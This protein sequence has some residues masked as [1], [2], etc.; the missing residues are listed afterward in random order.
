MGVSIWLGINAMKVL[1]ILADAGG[2]SVRM[3]IRGRGK[4][5]VVFEQFGPG[6]L[7]PWAK[8]QNG[9]AEFA[10]AVIYEHAGGMA[11]G[12]GLPPRDGKRISRELRD[13]LRSADLEPPFVMVGY[14]MAG[15]YVR[16]F[17]GEYPD[18]VAGLVLIDPSKEKFFEWLWENDPESH[19]IANWHLQ[20]KT[21]LGMT[22]ETFKQAA[23][24]GIP[25]VP[26][27][28]LTGGKGKNTVKGRL[29]MPRWIAAHRD[30]VA[31]LPKGRHVISKRSGHAIP[32]QEP[33]RVVEVI[34]QLVHEVRERP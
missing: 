10:T 27:V 20:A 11:S 5:V 18:E 14:S 6:P 29:S 19:K 23:A 17:A 24:A 15:P 8:I 2:H 4:P 13:A 31:R 33:E 26:T 32:F 25:H 28:V 22:K 7:E 16:V 1:P 9:V 12:A 34:R 3:M 30:Y 21:E